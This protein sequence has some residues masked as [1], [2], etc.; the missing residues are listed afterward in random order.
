MVFI[1][2]QIFGR[3]QFGRVAFFFYLLEGIMGPAGAGGPI[4]P[5]HLL[6]SYSKKQ[7]LRQ[8]NHLTTCKISI[9]PPY[10]TFLTQLQSEILLQ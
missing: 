1:I 7:R 6:C 2:L 9:L 5:L 4:L 3:G 10:V 8:L